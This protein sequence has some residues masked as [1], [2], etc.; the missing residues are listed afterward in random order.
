ML[1]RLASSPETAIEALSLL[2]E[3]QVYQV[4]LALQD[5]ELRA[6]RVELELLVK[7]QLQL[8]DASPAGSLTID[9]MTVITELNLAAARLLGLKRAAAIGR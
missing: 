6:S 5:E 2:H 1:H 9:Q 3:L 8:Y 4:E 7:R